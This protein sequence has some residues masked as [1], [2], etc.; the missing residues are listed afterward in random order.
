MK[1]LID[2][3]ADWCGPC[4]AMK[5]VVESLESEL[6]EKLVVKKVNVDTTPEEASKYNVVSIPTFVILDENGKEL[7]KRM[8]AIPKDQFVEWVKSNL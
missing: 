6:K 3:Y 2:F 5:P 1:T 8:G 7:A 4:I